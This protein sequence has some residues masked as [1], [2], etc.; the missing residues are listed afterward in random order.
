MDLVF[1]VLDCVLKFVVPV[2]DKLY[3][4]EVAIERVNILF[5][6]VN[7][8][9][10]TMLDVDCRVSQSLKSDHEFSLNLKSLLVI[11]L[12]PDCLP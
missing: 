3:M 10:D 9:C 1:L 12:L 5:N 8:V 11:V 4:V 2:H 7:Q 6:T